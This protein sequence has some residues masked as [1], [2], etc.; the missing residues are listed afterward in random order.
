MSKTSRKLLLIGWD[1]ADWQMIQPLMQAGKMPALKRFLDDGAVWG[2]LATIEPMLS[3]ML[4]T[5]IAT[6]KRADKHG[7]CG[8]VEP[9]ADGTNM[10]PVGSHTRTCKA[11]WNILNQEGYRCNVINWYATQPVEPIKGAMVSEMY[12]QLQHTKGKPFTVP[13][14]CV[15]P[16][17][18]SEDL[19]ELHVDFRELRG[20][21]LRP[22]I[23]TLQEIDMAKDNRPVL[24][25]REIANAAT[26][27]AATTHLIAGQD[28]D[29]TAT[30][31]PTIDHVAHHFIDY[32]PPQQ[33]HVNEED[34]RHYQH[35]FTGCYMFH[36]MLF[37][38]LLQQIDEDTA[39]MIVSDHGFHSGPHRPPPEVA[40][41]LP[42]MSH[43]NIGVVCLGGPGIKKHERLYGA[44]LLDVTPTILNY[45]GLP[46]A[47]DMDG[48][49][50]VEVFEETP[51]LEPIFSWDTRGES[52]QVATPVSDSEALE[53]ASE[54][55]LKQLMDLGYIDPVSEETQ[56]RAENTRIHNKI[57]LVEALLNSTRY[58]NA[59]PMLEE[60]LQTSTSADWCYYSLA[61]VHFKS[62]DYEQ[63]ADCLN[64]IS[65]EAHQDPRVELLCSE[66]A[67]MRGD[68]KAALTSLQAAEVL[69]P[70]MSQVHFQKGEIFLKLKR[71][72]EAKTSLGCAVELDASNYMAWN[73]FAAA[74]LA[75]EQN[76]EAAN[77]ALQAIEGIPHFPHAHYN[78]GVALAKSGEEIHAITAFESCE[79]IAP[80]SPGVYTWLARL[81]KERDPEK[82]ASYQAKLGKAKERPGFFVAE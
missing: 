16:E 7:I 37:H 1:A 15:W 68:L 71:W 46:T 82:A 77:A 51:R 54:A 58:K 47:L 65:K 55:M 80:D 74:C 72:E 26:V 32:H 76:E 14:G 48:R 34:F 69:A 23:P 20:E 64:K 21:D 13:L 66:V 18:L 30:F 75:L 40:E 33:P 8:F 10:Q 42:E 57:R 27:Q 31:F 61:K 73:S 6:G 38:S 24:L 81:F 79:R 22:L 62:G 44:T 12:A 60:L 50:W 41:N 29:F 53:D 52:R 25:A 39:V 35:V 43:R 11:L 63:A 5:S 56:E 3:P 36:D 4:W 28:W 2:N 78:L 67:L 59:I 19:R 70:H 17:H 45:F 49:S 9:S